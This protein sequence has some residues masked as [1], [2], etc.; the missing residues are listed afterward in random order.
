MVT[1]GNYQHV[2]GRLRID[3]TECKRALSFEHARGRHLTGRDSAEQAIGHG[4]ILT[5]G[6]LSRLPTYMVATLS[7]ASAPRARPAPPSP[8]RA[9][10]T[11]KRG[12]PGPCCPSNNLVGG[13]GPFQAPGP[14][15]SC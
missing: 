15:K 2:N 5:C 7:T 1:L 8:R 13:P 10:S 4:P 9:V 12:R 3:V 6:V 14:R 11:R